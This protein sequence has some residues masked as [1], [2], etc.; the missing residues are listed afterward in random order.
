MK[1]TSRVQ[2]SGRDGAPYTGNVADGFRD[3]V[4]EID[5]GEERRKEGHY[6]PNKS[7]KRSSPPS[8]EQ[9]EFLR[10]AKLKV[11]KVMDFDRSGGREE[12]LMEEMK[13]KDRQLEVER[14]YHAEQF[15]RMTMKYEDMLYDLSVE[16]NQLRAENQSIQKK[17]SASTFTI[18]TQTSPQHLPTRI[19]FLENQ[20]ARL[21]K[22]LAEQE[23][24]IQHK[25]AKLKALK[26]Y[27]LKSYNL[28]QK[29]MVDCV[30]DS[31]GCVNETLKHFDEV[32]QTAFT[33]AGVSEQSLQQES[34][35]DLVHKF[36]EGLHASKKLFFS[37]E[38]IE[39]GL[40]ARIIV[41][42]PDA[43]ET[44]I[45]QH[46]S[47]K[48]DGLK[49][50]VSE[51]G[52]LNEMLMHFIEANST[53]NLFPAIREFALDLVY[54]EKE[55]LLSVY[56]DMQEKGCVFNQWIQKM[57]EDLSVFEKKSALISD[58][59]ECLKKRISHLLHII[60]LLEMNCVQ[61]KNSTQLLF[62]DHEETNNDSRLVFERAFSGLSQDNFKYESL[63]RDSATRDDY[64]KLKESYA[65]LEDMVVELV[66]SN[67]ELVEKLNAPDH[68][69][70]PLESGLNK[71]AG[72]KRNLPPASLFS[73][74]PYKGDGNGKREVNGNESFEANTN[75]DDAMIETISSANTT[76]ETTSEDI[77]R[78]TENFSK[79]CSKTEG[80]AM[81]SPVGAM[82]GR[83]RSFNVGAL[84]S[85][86]LR[87]EVTPL[88]S[89]P[90]AKEIMQNNM[91]TPITKSKNVSKLQPWRVSNEP[92]VNSTLNEITS[93]SL[94]KR[95]ISVG[96]DVLKEFPNLGK[97]TSIDSKSTTL[98]SSAV[99][100]N[101]QKAS[102]SGQANI[103]SKWSSK[104][105][106]FVANG[107]II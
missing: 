15:E 98:G 84:P 106:N 14:N 91:F 23:I 73:S 68:I 94:G 43:E 83:S 50:V 107:G 27:H 63:R 33:A 22:K 39:N 80:S 35:T 86:P 59:R 31:I 79:F 100:Q 36:E 102:G 7:L 78:L 65:M 55:R 19:T 42:S 56:P 70:A 9:F 3:G 58:F 45:E 54:R 47:M 38:P 16:N 103:G 37:S 71:S 75:L 5:E 95:R 2:L 52:T 46:L 18:S 24:E 105:Y 60:P 57:E 74:S 4:F 81:T 13:A 29:S 92:S 34:P 26:S 93:P 89:S 8:P 104:I 51:V 99:E 48:E 66:K 40:F 77:L 32:L 96:A 28:S 1:D 88:C 11:T 25:D 12:M 85:S 90:M 67:G 76:D 64:E 21:S 87:N 41:N 61:K 53:A 49:Q 10:G 20:I 17:K 62:E 44:E 69:V 97:N 101:G 30:E 72:L 6:A 82:G